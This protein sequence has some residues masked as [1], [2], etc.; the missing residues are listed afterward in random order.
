MQSQ[1]VLLKKVG[2]NNMSACTKIAIQIN[3]KLEGAL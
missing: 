2:K 3:F 1:V